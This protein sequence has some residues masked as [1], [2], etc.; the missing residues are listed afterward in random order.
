LN[1][2]A[3]REQLGIAM[4]MAH[5]EAQGFKRWLESLKALRRRLLGS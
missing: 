1:E 3:A 2:I 4:R 5:A